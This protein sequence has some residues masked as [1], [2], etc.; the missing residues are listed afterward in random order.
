MEDEDYSMT[1]H[2]FR[3]NKSESPA[4]L[5]EVTVVNVKV[6]ST[7][8]MSEQRRSNYGAKIEVLKRAG[9]FYIC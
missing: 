7:F 6:T 8:S 2:R 5:I 3:V 1:L 4:T 9:K